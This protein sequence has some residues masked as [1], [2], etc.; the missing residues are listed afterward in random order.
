MN[1]SPQKFPKVMVGKGYRHR[2]TN[3]N[4]VYEGLR[5]KGI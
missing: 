5:L 1:L 4:N 2:K 3:G